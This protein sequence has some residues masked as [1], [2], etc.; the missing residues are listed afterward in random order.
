MAKKP[1]KRFNFDDYGDDTEP[2]WLKQRAKLLKQKGTYFQYASEETYEDLMAIGEILRN[3]E[4]QKYYPSP[5]DIFVPVPDKLD[6]GFDKDSIVRL[7][8][9]EG[10]A[11]TSFVTSNIID[12]LGYVV[13]HKESKNFGP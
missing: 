13:E 3:E 4:Y 11:V 9:K 5:P 7:K 12:D 6:E 1:K 10:F 2:P 8:Y